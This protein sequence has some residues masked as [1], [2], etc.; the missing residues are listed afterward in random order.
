M[1][2]NTEKFDGTNQ[3]GYNKALT[4]ASLELFPGQ[5]L[6]SGEPLQPSLSGS[7]ATLGLKKLV[8]LMGHCT[9]CLRL[10]VGFSWFVDGL[11]LISLS[12]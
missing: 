2:K 6:P 3:H 12:A 10:R 7:G 8:I 11:R 9:L 4:L 5:I 1:V